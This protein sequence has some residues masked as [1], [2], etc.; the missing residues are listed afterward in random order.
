M[1]FLIFSDSHGNV[2]NMSE[3]IR[4]NPT[5]RTV[6]FLGDG[7]SDL[8]TLSELHP[9][10]DIRAVRGNCDPFSSDAPLEGTLTLYGVTVYLCHGHIHGVKSALGP[11]IA[12][13]KQEGASVLLFGHTHL[14]HNEYLPEYGMHIFN[15]G[16]IGRT[17]DGAPSFG[18][19]D[20]L[21]DGGVSLSHGKLT[22]KKR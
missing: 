3:A 9:T 14:T 7:L 22:P 18:I 1:Q 4:R 5:V 15:P 12:R 8:K 17:W 10:L 21:P 2:A 11:A 16:S 19:L 20:I 6:L 13:A